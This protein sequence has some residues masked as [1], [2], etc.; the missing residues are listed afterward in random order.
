MA[1]E[2]VDGD[3]DES[4]L[5]TQFAKEGFVGGPDAGEAAVLDGDA[6]LGA[7]IAHEWHL[8]RGRGHGVGLDGRALRIFRQQWHTGTEPGGGDAFGVE[9]DH[10]AGPVAAAAVSPEG[11]GDF[12]KFRVA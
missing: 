11:P 3:A 8:Q 12:G 5:G 4:A 10:S 6:F 7:G 1:G 9:Q 2:G